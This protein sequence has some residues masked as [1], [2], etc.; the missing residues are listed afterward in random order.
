MKERNISRNGMR[1]FFLSGI[2]GENGGSAKDGLFQEGKVASTMDGPWA[3]QALDDAGIDFGV[4][5]L[6][7]LP[8][9]KYPT[10]FRWSKRMA[11]VCTI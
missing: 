1:I 9:G 6:P 2:I 3:Y 11:F 5:P 7:K 10:D 8:N 4:T